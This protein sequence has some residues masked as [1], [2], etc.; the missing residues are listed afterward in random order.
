MDNGHVFM[1]LSFKL[2]ALV[3]QAGILNVFIFCPIH[4]PPCDL[5]AKC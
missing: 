3:C 2:Y 1:F 4:F 5:P